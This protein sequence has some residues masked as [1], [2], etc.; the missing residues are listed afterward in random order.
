MLEYNSINHSFTCKDAENAAQSASSVSELELWERA[1]L[2][3]IAD[4]GSGYKISEA[5]F[6]RDAT[7]R[8]YKLSKILYLLDRVIK[9]KDNPSKIND[10]HWKTRHLL[11]TFWTAVQRYVSAHP[12][13]EDC[14]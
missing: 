13:T 11:L 14:C 8:C 3:S 7:I 2:S 9:N 4:S 10:L 1:K 12:R 6:L 5:M